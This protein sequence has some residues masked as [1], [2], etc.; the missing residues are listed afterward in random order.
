MAG[1]EGSSTSSRIRP[2]VVHCMLPFGKIARKDRWTD[3]QG[4]HRAS[5]LVSALLAVIRHLLVGIG[6]RPPPLTLA[7]ALSVPMLTM[8]AIV[9]MSMT[10]PS[11]PASC[12]TAHPRP[13]IIGTVAPTV[14][15]AAAI[16][17]V[18]LRRALPYGPGFMIDAA[19]LTTLPAQAL[20]VHNVLSPADAWAA[21]LASLRLLCLR[22]ADV[23][24]AQTQNQVRLSAIGRGRGARR[25]G[26][27]RR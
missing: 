3:A 12:S 11:F 8:S 1:K 4:A 16:A 9:P 27:R 25:A 24:A 18:L 26:A 6:A 22:A 13:A 14:I 7:L 10:L 20:V 23:R 2:D 19:H 21:F 15:V 5:G 17:R